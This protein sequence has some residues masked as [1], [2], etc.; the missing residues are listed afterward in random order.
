MD[1]G[2]LHSVEKSLNLAS[3]FGRVFLMFKLFE[4]VFELAR[5]AV[6]FDQQVFM[7]CFTLVRSISGSLQ[8][9]LT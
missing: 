5:V 4:P 7:S 2:C 8:G 1:R 6:L 9:G 3:R